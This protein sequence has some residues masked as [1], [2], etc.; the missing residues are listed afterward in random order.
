MR[1][2]TQRELEILQDHTRWV[3]TNGRAGA[4]ADLRRADLRRAD[5]GGADLRGA[6]LTG[7]DLEGA[8]LRGADLT[9]ATP[10]PTI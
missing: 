7:A 8:D 10:R 5:L 4:R 3:E 2:L 1:S 9:R 6:D